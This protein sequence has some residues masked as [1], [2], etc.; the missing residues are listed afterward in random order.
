[1]RRI[2]AIA[3]IAVLSAVFVGS[4]STAGAQT[5]PVFTCSFTLS[6]TSLPAGGGPVLVSG[7]APGDTVVHIF[8]NGVEVTTAH[9]DNVTGAWGP[10]Q[11][12]I[13]A[14]STIG[15]SIPSSYPACPPRTVTVATPPLPRTGSNDTKPF[16][17][18]GV[19]VLLVGV[20]LVFAARR[21]ENARG[22]A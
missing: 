12:T 7:T 16:V 3:G 17:L 9:S 11:L 15:V 5:T 18:A 8:V 19:T 2:L 21:R 13:T 10:V 6:T 22:R 4:V 14:T 1:M 20:A